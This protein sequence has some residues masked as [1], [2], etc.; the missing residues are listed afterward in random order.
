MKGGPPRK[1]F[2]SGGVS[3]WVQTDTDPQVKG[4]TGKTRV[5]RAEALYKWY[6]SGIF[7]ANLGDDDFLPIPPIKGSRKQPLTT[8]RTQRNEPN[9]NPDLLSAAQRATLKLVLTWPGGKGCT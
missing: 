5:V 2:T 1:P 7:L 3:L 6:I 8:K 4:M 9:E